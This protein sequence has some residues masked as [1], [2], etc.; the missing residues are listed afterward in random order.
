VIPNYVSTN[1]YVNKEI[2]DNDF[3]TSHLYNPE[4][5]RYAWDASGKHKKLERAEKLNVFSLTRKQIETAVDVL[6]K[7]EV[8]DS[9]Y[10]VLSKY[11]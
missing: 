8:Y 6:N 5:T 4:V 3:I 7:S 10:H 9:V 2:W 11:F 1:A